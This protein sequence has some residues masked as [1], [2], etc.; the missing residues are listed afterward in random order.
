MHTPDI[1]SE[2]LSLLVS[3]ESGE[4]FV[5]YKRVITVESLIDRETWGPAVMILHDAREDLSS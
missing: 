4:A 2:S 3:V 1:I 5:G